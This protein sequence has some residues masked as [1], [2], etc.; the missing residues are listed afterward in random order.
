[1]TCHGC[2]GLIVEPG[3]AYGYAGRVCHCCRCCGCNHYGPP[4]H[5]A[6]FP[7]PVEKNQL[8]SEILEKLLELIEKEKK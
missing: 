6:T 1:M 3:K 2:G 7:K 5:W 4:P 8:T